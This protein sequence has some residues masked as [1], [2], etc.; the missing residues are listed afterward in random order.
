[1]KIRKCI[2]GLSDASRYWYL[3]LRE[4][5]I[6]L[7]ATPMQLDQGIFI[8]HKNKI[9]IGIMACFVDDILW[10]GNSE[11]ENTISKLKQIFCI[12]AEHEQIFHYIGIRLEQK[13]VFSITITQKEYINSICPIP[14]TKDD[15]KNPNRKL[16]QTETTKLRGILGKLNWVSGM[17]RPEISFFVCETSTRI[18]DATVSDLISANKIVKFIQNTP[19]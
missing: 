17:T 14:L 2:Y 8:W 1:M 15:H 4:E 6:K 9:S 19:C 11:F 13:P 16:S 12:S 18:K 3:K 10:G 5:L 7:G